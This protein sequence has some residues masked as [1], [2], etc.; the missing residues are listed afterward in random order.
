MGT[1][2]LPLPETPQKDSKSRAALCE[3][4]ATRPPGFNALNFGVDESLAGGINNSPRLD[5]AA[6]GMGQ[7]LLEFPIPVSPAIAVS[8]G[9]R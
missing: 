7:H 8:L 2:T 1:N 5:A 4:I 3:T 6:K 9:E